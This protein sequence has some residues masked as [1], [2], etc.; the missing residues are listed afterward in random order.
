MPLKLKPDNLILGPRPGKKSLPR[1]KEL[2]LTHCVTLLS[3]REGGPAIEKLSRQMGADWVW[4][5]L[6]GGHMETLGQVDPA[7]LA[8]T[9]SAATSDTPAPKLYLH[10]SAGIHRTGF[11]AHMLLRLSGLTSEEAQSALKQMREVTSEQV[12][13]D[14]IALAD[15][16]VDGV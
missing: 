10:C 16:L 4:F 3:E 7:E 6:S 15:Q 8:D 5:P 13:P 12:G 11:V 2:G 9:I 1:L 14:R